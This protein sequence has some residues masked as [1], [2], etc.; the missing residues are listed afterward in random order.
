MNCID[1]E[2]FTDP[3]PIY[4]YRIGTFMPV[5]QGTYRFPKSKRHDP[6]KITVYNDSFYD[7]TQ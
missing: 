7:P 2:L 1:M 3:R 5:E 6:S 4:T